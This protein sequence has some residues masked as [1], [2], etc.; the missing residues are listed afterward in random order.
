MIGTDVR[1]RHFLVVG[2]ARSGVGIARLLLNHGARVSGA[3]ARGASALGAFARALE[4]DGLVL[5]ADDPGAVVLDGVDAIVLSPGVPRSAPLVAEAS[6]RGLPII[7][8]LELAARFARAP[9]IAVTGTNGKS[10]TVTWIGHLLQAMA[11]PV[12]VAGNVGTALSAVVETV[13]A[14]G[15]LVVEVSSFQLETTDTFR[16]TVGVALNL[17]P[18]HLDRYDSVADYYAAKERLFLRQTP[19]DVAVLNAADPLLM[20]WAPRLSARLLTFGGPVAGSAGARL[21]DG[22]LGLETVAGFVPLV[23]ASR[24]GIPGP[25]NVQNALAAIAALH[26]LGVDVTDPRFVRGLEDFRGLE[27]RL[28]YLGELN[29]VRFYNDSKATNTDSLAVAL[30]SFTEPVVL[31]AGG[32]DKKGDFPALAPVVSEHVALVVTIGEAATTIRKAWSHVVSDWVSAGTSFERAVESAY[33]E[34][35]ARGA[36]V[37]LSPGCASFDMFQD[38]EDRGRQFKKLVVQLGAERFLP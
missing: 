37:L 13:P 21:V 11:R 9:I 14:E 23:P 32:R 5:H 16:P 2:L 18:D 36:V 8:E 15:V 35:A 31:I 27:H 7:G 1:G 20:S 22:Q 25:H 26:G 29:G 24:L 33:Q 4:A 17:A 6:R 19:D 12:V 3:D 10:T 28:E 34:A 38:Y 30:A